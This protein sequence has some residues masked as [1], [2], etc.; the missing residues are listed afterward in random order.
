L[1]EGL[2][3][4]EI[5]TGDVAEALADAYRAFRSASHRLALQE[6][7]ALVSQEKLVQERQQVKG[8]WDSVMSQKG[9]S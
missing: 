1:L 2:A 9:P 7:P 6:R 4:H 8:I 3:R 5:F